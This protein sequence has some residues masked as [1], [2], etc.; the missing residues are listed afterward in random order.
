MCHMTRLIKHRRRKL[1]VLQLMLLTS[2]I[3]LSYVIMHIRIVLVMQ[4]MYVT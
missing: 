2:V 3:V 4:T 1:A